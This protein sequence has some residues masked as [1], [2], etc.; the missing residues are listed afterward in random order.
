MT[1]SSL[2]RS[3]MACLLTAQLAGCATNTLP[4]TATARESAAA[5]ATMTGFMSDVFRVLD[6]DGNRALA[7]GEI[8]LTPAQFQVL[9]QD[10]DGAIAWREWTAEANADQ[11]GRSQAA[12]RP[13]AEAE[14]RQRAEGG[15]EDLRTEGVRVGLAQR[16]L[17]PY[18]SLMSRI[19]APLAV[20]PKRHPV[21]VTPAQAGWAYEDVSFK[22]EDGLTIKGWYVPAK[23]ASKKTLVMVHGIT[24]NRDWFMRTGMLAMVHDEY[25]VLAIDLRAHGESE[26]RVTSFGYHES[27][28]VIAA[29]KYLKGRGLDQVAL[30]GVS[31]GGASAI[32]AAAVL[33][34]VRAVVSD[35]A[36]AT[37]RHA[38]AGFITMAKVPSPQ[39]VA[40]AT[41]ARANR[42]VGVD[43]ADT[44]PL[45]QVGKLAPRPFFVIHGEKDKNVSVENSRLN[46]EAAGNGLK[47]DLW[48]VPGGIHAE[49]V[50]AQPAAYRQR[51]LAF[52][53]QAW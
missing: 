1:T 44:E 23:S 31:L 35:C 5:G 10:G 4:T 32:R 30:Y 26:G 36:Y 24:A 27:L 28:D 41:V 9:D 13:V 6:I 42:L 45:T 2:R 19:A 50:L 37:V 7:A 39:L 8:D 15:A 25:N 34:E 18:L 3:L 14:S 11:L 52:L 22:A 43:M 51:L 38:F 16:L 12:F 47:K 48:I 29:V 17:G 49:S 40:A 46:F 20:H 33:P 21:K 53:E